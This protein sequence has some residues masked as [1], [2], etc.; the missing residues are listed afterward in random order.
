MHHGLI[1]VQTLAGG[2]GIVRFGHIMR[3]SFPHGLLQQCAWLFPH[4]CRVIL[5]LHRCWTNP[6]RGWRI[7]RVFCYRRTMV[8]YPRFA[9]GSLDD[10]RSVSGVSP[11]VSLQTSRYVTYRSPIS[12]LSSGDHYLDGKQHLPNRE[13]YRCIKS[14]RFKC[15]INFLINLC[16]FVDNSGMTPA[17]ML[18][19]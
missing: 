5:F 3:R 15:A 11:W 4:A 13:A 2:C 10:L 8:S 18:L 19:S 9:L 16:V 12:C 17:L 1:Q 14:Y 6:P 7:Y